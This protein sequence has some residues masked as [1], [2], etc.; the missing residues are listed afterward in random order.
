MRNI[1]IKCTTMLFLSAILMLLA[2]FLTTKVEARSNP[3]DLNI[4]TH[5]VYFFPQAIYPNW[6]QVQRAELLSKADY[7]QNQDVVIFNELFDKE[8]SSN[9]LSNLADRYP[10]QTPIIGSSKKEWDKTSGTYKHIRPANGGVNIVSKWPIERQEQHIFKRGCGGEGVSN[11][12]FAYVK[13]NKNG[14]PYHIIGMH[15]QS[16]NRACIKGKDVSIREE[17]MKEVRDFVKDKNIPKDETV[18][19]GGDLNVIKGSENYNRMLEI[20]NVSEPTGY[21]GQSQSWDT[22]TNSIAQYNYPDLE[23]QQLDYILTEKDHK[24]PTQ[25]Y[26]ET[27]DDKSPKWNVRSWG[28]DYQYDDYSDHYPVTAYAS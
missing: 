3:D 11:K 10:Y 27:R 13:I 6:G 21:R 15:L 2:I 23:P 16:E 22:Q 8:A 20:L 26:N 12:G 19:I 24:Q 5:N 14:K 28:K 17:Q 1:V 4:A 25:W 9:L 18:L 7:I